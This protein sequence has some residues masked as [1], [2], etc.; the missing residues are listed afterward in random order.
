MGESGLAYAL[1]GLSGRLRWHCHF[2]QK[3]E[4]EPVIEHNNFAR[5]SDGL[6]A[7][8]RTNAKAKK[9]AGAPIENLQGDLF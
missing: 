4:D 1:R 2:M 9:S 3:L 6:R 8:A 5:S 7:Q